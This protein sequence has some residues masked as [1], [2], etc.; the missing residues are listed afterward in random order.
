MFI[1]FLLELFHLILLQIIL[2]IPII[3]TVLYS[4]V[5]QREHQR[6]R[7]ECII[8]SQRPPCIHACMT[9]HGMHALEYSPRVTDL[10]YTNVQQSNVLVSPLTPS[11]RRL[12]PLKRLAGG[13]ASHPVTVYQ[14]SHRVH[15]ESCNQKGKRIKVWW[16]RPLKYQ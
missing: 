3:P 13:E 12:H 16:I 14:Y 11:P 7:S 4:V 5:M 1:Y 6:L 8:D 2:F 10:Q 15:M 9:W